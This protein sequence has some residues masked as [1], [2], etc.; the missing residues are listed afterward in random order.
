MGLLDQIIGR[1]GGEE[2]IERLG[3]EEASFDDLQSPD[4]A[5]WN[6]LVGAA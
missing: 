5:H 3:R 1:L 2:P 4:F 6:E